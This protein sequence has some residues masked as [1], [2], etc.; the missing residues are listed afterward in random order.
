MNLFL[1]RTIRARV[2]ADINAV[3]ALINQQ[4]R[5]MTALEDQ[6]RNKQQA[7]RSRTERDSMTLA[8]L[9]AATQ[10]AQVRVTQLSSLPARNENIAPTFEGDLTPLLNSVTNITHRMAL[11]A[12]RQGHS[13]AQ[14][15]ESTYQVTSQG[16]ALREAQAT[17][18]L[19]TRIRQLN[20]TTLALAR[21]E[22][23]LRNALINIDPEA[24]QDVYDT[25]KSILLMHEARLPAPLLQQLRGTAENIEIRRQQFA[26]EEAV[27]QRRCLQLDNKALAMSLIVLG[28]IIFSSRLEEKN[29]L[30]LIG[31]LFLVCA[32]Y[33]SSQYAISGVTRVWRQTEDIKNTVRTIAIRFEQSLNNLDDT[34][35]STS[36]AV[37]T[38]LLD[39]RN[40]TARMITMVD[41]RAEAGF[42]QAT[43]FGGRLAD[44]LGGH[45]DLLG[46]NLRDGIETAGDSI[47]RRMP[48]CVIL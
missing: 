45:I 43:F 17:A 29:C 20:R 5:D 38:F 41:Q 28:G 37:N 14:Q 16:I 33:K 21:I 42:N 36:T 44:N 2:T 23:K 8:R 26:I 27:Q 35:D 31:L 48:C 46:E 22:T 13:Q 34:A 6:L 30:N 7:T 1:K 40:Q 11:S 12:E 3:A 32:V 9:H 19:Q 39:M 25:C 4:T 24:P 15:E 47:A 10:A 18:D